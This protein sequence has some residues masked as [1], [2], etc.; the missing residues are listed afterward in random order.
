MYLSICRNFCLCEV[1]DQHLPNMTDLTYMYKGLT[2]NQYALYK[3]MYTGTDI[4]QHV[5][6]TY[7]ISFQNMIQ[8]KRISLTSK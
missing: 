8:I 1:F 7:L 3:Y 4:M 5:N 6:G 2:M